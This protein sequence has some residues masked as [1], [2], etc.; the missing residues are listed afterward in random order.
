MTPDGHLR[1]EGRDRVR[2]CEVLLQTLPAVHAR[3][4]FGAVASTQAACRR[5][6]ELGEHAWRRSACPPGTYDLPCHAEMRWRH[7]E[8]ASGPGTS[9]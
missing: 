2:A 3:I 8:S 9:K 1:V 5:S 7:A 4:W 6:S